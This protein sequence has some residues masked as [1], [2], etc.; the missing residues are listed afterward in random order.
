MR[1]SLRSLGRARLLVAR[2]LAAACDLD[3][4][5]IT[6]RLTY[7]KLF[8][9]IIILQHCYLYNLVSVQSPRSIWSSSVVTISRPHISSSLRITNRSFRYAAPHLWN[10]WSKNYRRLESRVISR[11]RIVLRPRQSSIVC[12]SIVLKI[13][14][15]YAIKPTCILVRVR[16]SLVHIREMSG[17]FQRRSCIPTAWQVLYGKTES[18]YSTKQGTNLNNN[19]KLQA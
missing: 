16:Y 19:Q 5:L 1:L 18:S 2:R 12:L 15:G 10:H 4:I 13:Q 11:N 7:L 9:T 3:L 6:K 14:H 8:S 17:S